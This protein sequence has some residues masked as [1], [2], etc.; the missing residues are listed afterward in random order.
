MRPLRSSSVTTRWWRTDHTRVISSPV[1]GTILS[2]QQAEWFLD[3]V[4][5]GH[6]SLPTSTHRSVRRWPATRARSWSCRAGSGKTGSSPIPH[7]PSDPRSRGRTRRHPG[8]HLHQQG[9]R[10]DEGPSRLAR[11]RCDQVNVGIHVS[12]GLCSCASCEASRLGYRSG[13]S[14]YDEADSLRLINLVLKDLDVDPKRF[15]PRAMKAVISKA[16][17]ELVDYEAFADQGMGSS[18]SKWRTYI[19]S[20]SSVCS[21][22][23]PWI[24][25]ISSW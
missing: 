20:I 5:A 11:G 18:T 25:T 2:M 15:P 13:F 14:I 21:R 7:R 16:K 19:A 24:S 1:T 4:P 10:R 12:F 22:R 3:D 6:H 9:R 8:Y 17:N 23:R